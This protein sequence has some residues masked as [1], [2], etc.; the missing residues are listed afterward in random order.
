MI[1]IILFV[2]TLIPRIINL[3]F[4]VINIDALFWKENTYNFLGLLFQG[5]FSDMAITHH[6]GVTLMWMAS[7]TTKLFRGV[8]LLLNKVPAPDTNSMF[9][10]QHFWHKLP[11]VI[12]SS[13]FVLLVYWSVKKL[14]NDKAALFAAL[15]VS[16]EPLFIA[17]SRVFQT[18]ALLT[19]FMIGSVLLYLVY[20]S[21][22]AR[23]GKI[24]RFRH[25]RTAWPNGPSLG[26]FLFRWVGEFAR[27]NKLLIFSGILGG[28]ALLTKSNT[29]F[30]IPFIAL[31]TLVKLGYESEGFKKLTA[32]LLKK[33]LLL[34]F[35]FYLLISA[36]FVAAWPSMWTNPGDTLNLYV[37]GITLE[38][39]DR[40]NRHLFFGVETFDPGPFFYPL[41]LIYRTS[42]FTL[43]L[44][45]G[46][47]I[48]FLKNL[49]K[50][51]KRE[52]FV[53]D[54]LLLFFV[55][56][57][58]E[59][60]LPAKKLDRYMLPNF[61]VVAILG[62]YVV[63]KII[64]HLSKK[65]NIKYIIGSIFSI[66]LFIFSILLYRSYHPDELAYFSP[67]V[68]GFRGGQVLTDAWWWGQ[69]Y[70]KAADY[71][72]NPPAGGDRVEETKVA[73]YDFRSFKPFYNGVTLDA[74]NK[75]EFAQ[76]DYFIASIRDRE[77]FELEYVVEIANTPY[78]GVYKRLVV[79]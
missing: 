26:E 69:G 10:W 16:F 57:L 13:L 55:F 65:Y 56:Y 73:L 40:P 43:L 72:N 66:L 22:K 32:V 71:L 34:I 17:H 62:G 6:P 39:A 33:Y 53:I 21:E 76:A 29:L 51:E 12:I 77:G 19:S 49:R 52:R 44:F 59:I 3:G 74:G 27:S 20:L 31:I 4:D 24:Q 8:Y 58:L 45:V 48:W 25:S 7:V 15:L 1:Y 42:P 37:S 28:L 2:I 23:E 79:E 41:V 18:D 38:G 46:G 70:K 54:S 36:T 30:L 50:L 47:L 11:I 5:R 61:I 78:L 64:D 14:F 63:S 35:A 9:L 60:T 68:G 75:D 67:L